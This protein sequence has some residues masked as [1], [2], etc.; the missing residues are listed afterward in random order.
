MDMEAQVMVIALPA[1]APVIERTFQVE[2]RL[3][4]LEQF[5]FE[6]GMARPG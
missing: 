3:N 4:W 1:A 5:S 2:L 6:Q